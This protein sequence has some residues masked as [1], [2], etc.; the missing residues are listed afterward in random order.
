MLRNTY[1][2]RDWKEKEYENLAG[3]ILRRFTFLGGLEKELSFSY[4]LS[5]ILKNIQY[6]IILH[7]KK[8]KC[9]LSTLKDVPICLKISVG[10]IWIK[11]IKLISDALNFVG[12]RKKK[13]DYEQK[14]L[15]IK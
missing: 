9:I 13:I 10:D 3:K 8:K 15:I 14:T 12:R 2:N 4:I 11:Y 1:E 7:W 6:K 5:Y